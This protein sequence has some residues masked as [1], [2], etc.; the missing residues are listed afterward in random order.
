M[1]YIH[2]NAALNTPERNIPGKPGTESATSNTKWGTSWSALFITWNMLFHRSIYEYY[3]LLVYKSIGHCI[4]I[5]FIYVYFI[6][7]NYE[8]N[9]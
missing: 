3:S 2:L 6:Q 8:L 9:N 5:V 4:S 7:S 1:I